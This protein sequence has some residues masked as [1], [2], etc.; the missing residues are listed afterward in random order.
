MSK[1]CIPPVTDSGKLEDSGDDSLIEPEFQLH[2]MGRQALSLAADLVSEHDLE[3]DRAMARWHSDRKWDDYLDTSFVDMELLIQSPDHERSCQRILSRVHVD[4]GDAFEPDG[5]RLITVWNW[6]TVYVPPRVHI[7]AHVQPGFLP[8]HVLGG[9][10]HS[11]DLDVAGRR[12]A[13]RTSGSHGHAEP[14]FNE[15]ECALAHAVVFLDPLVYDPPG[16]VEGE[17]HRVC[18]TLLTLVGLDVERRMV[19]FKVTIQETEFRD[20]PAADIGQERKA[21]GVRT[22]KLTQYFGPI[23]ADPDEP[24]AAPIELRQDLLQ[25]N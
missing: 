21:N 8:A 19:R 25:L 13:L 18:D 11:R 2:T 22:R 6:S 23:V 20:H 15:L 3:I 1:T 9:I 17:D 24:D 14:L 4:L 10:R 16:L 7:D 5:E 12:G